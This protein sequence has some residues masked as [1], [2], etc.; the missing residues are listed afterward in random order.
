MDIQRTDASTWA[1]KIA[2]LPDDARECVREYLRGI[3]QRG[4]VVNG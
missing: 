4:R 1:G 3:Y 2:T